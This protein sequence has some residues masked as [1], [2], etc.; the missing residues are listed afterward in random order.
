MT[1]QTRKENLL[2]MPPENMPEKSRYWGTVRS[3]S[4]YFV[5][6]LYESKCFLIVLF[7]SGPL[8]LK[9]FGSYTK[10]FSVISQQL[11]LL[12][13]KGALKTY[14]LSLP[15]HKILKGKTGPLWEI[16]VSGLPS[17]WWLSQGDRG[18][19]TASHRSVM[20]L[21][22]LQITCHMLLSQ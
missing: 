15:A 5:S 12:A 11:S 22:L 4:Y 18:D 2:R 9:L 3:A 6:C 14:F 13:L 21:P 20:F 17:D 8:I 16:Y 19:T 10:E 7:Q 1:L